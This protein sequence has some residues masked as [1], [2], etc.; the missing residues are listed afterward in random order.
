MVL[1]A[2][3]LYSFQFL[4]S[5]VQINRVIVSPEL[6]GQ[7]LLVSLPQNVAIQ[8]HRLLQKTH[9]IGIY[10][11]IPSHVGVFWLFFELLLYRLLP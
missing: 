10:I 11:L 8:I 2:S 5:N 3:V 1:W 6:S 4:R 9:Q 7:E